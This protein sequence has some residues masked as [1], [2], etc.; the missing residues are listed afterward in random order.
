MPRDTFNLTCCSVYSVASS[1]LG[2][3]TKAKDFRTDLVDALYTVRR[4]DTFGHD[5]I[6]SITMCLNLKLNSQY[7]SGGEGG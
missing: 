4:R 6:A 5:M 1:A 7:V 2:L 3:L